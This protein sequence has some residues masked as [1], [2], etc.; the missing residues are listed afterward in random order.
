MSA[1]LV[2]LA[3]GSIFVGYLFKDAFIGLGTP[4]FSHSPSGAAALGVSNAADASIAAEFLPPTIALA[5]VAFSL[6]GAGLA[7][8]GYG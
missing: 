1:P 5:P 4:F 8:L 6:L 7:A 3:L 2:L